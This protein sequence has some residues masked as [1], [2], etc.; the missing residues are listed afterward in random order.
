[1]SGGIN[2][3]FDYKMSLFTVFIKQFTALVLIS[4]LIIYY[5]HII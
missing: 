2:R 4:R 3:F 1:M 5:S